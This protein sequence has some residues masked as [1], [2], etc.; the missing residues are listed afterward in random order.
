MKSIEAWTRIGLK[1]PVIRIS[2]EIHLIFHRNAL[3]NYL[4]PTLILFLSPSVSTTASTF[5]RQPSQAYPFY[6]LQRGEGS[7]QVAEAPR[8]T[9]LLDQECLRTF[10]LDRAETILNGI[11]ASLW[12]SSLSH[13]AGASTLPLIPYRSSTTSSYLGFISKSAQI[14]KTGP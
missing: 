5:P 9:S 1:A 3:I 4:C 6:P 7:N 2:I 13:S 10:L 14:W 8:Q 11:S 12:L